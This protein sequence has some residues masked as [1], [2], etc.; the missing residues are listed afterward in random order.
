MVEDVEIINNSKVVIGRLHEKTTMTGLI[1]GKLMS[2]YNKPILLVHESNGQCSG[3][4]RSPIP[5]KDIFT[6]SG[7]FDLNQGHLMAYGT[8]YSL[9]NEQAIIDYLDSVLVD[10]EPCRDVLISLP[11]KSIHSSLFSFVEI[12]NIFAKFRYVLCSYS[13]IHHL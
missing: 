6:D 8:S 4:V 13:T 9:S 3:S 2:K 10:C 11:I 7:L 1:A 5:T 12:T